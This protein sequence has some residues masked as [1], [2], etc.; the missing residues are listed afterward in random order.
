M[1]KIRNEMQEAID[2]GYRQEIQS[3]YFRR[4]IAF[5]HAEGRLSE[6]LQAV[7]YH[8]Q[9]P[10]L[11]VRA[12]RSLGPWLV[13]LRKAFAPSVLAQRFRLASWGIPLCR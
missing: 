4:S 5:A 9:E 8:R 3:D 13:R 12:I 10:S 1:A 2:E 11:A 7:G 6:L